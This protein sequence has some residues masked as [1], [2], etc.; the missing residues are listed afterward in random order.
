MKRPAAHFSSFFFAVVV[1][2][3]RFCSMNACSKEEA[4]PLK[5]SKKNKISRRRF[6]RFGFVGA[7]VA[8]AWAGTSNSFAARFIRER[9]N[10]VG[11]PIE[12]PKTKP[13][14]DKWDDNGIHASWLGH[15]T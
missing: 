2:R 3:N 6:V 11:R 12:N 9:W 7:A 13:T 1:V 15:S 4:S 5:S 8:G 14:P 10:E